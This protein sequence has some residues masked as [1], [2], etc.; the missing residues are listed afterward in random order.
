MLWSPSLLARI[1]LCC[2][3]EMEDYCP[4][5]IEFGMHVRSF[6]QDKTVLQCI[7]GGYWTEGVEA[8]RQRKRE[9]KEGGGV[10]ILCCM[11]PM[12]MI[13]RNVVIF[14]ASHMLCLHYFLILCC[15]PLV[16]LKSDEATKQHV[17][18]LHVYI[19]VHIVCLSPLL[20]VTLGTG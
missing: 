7:L 1:V 10:R 18:L 4:S 3:Q 19:H 16:L 13:S 2:L 15:H 11:E 17:Q 6:S 12:I 8:E 9:R 20:G 5:V 14:M